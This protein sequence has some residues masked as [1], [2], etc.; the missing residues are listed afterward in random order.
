[1]V[2][3]GTLRP[4]LQPTK[5][6]SHPTFIISGAAQTPAP[7]IEMRDVNAAMSKSKKI[8]IWLIRILVVF[9]ML[10]VLTMVLSPRLIN[11]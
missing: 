3:L 7:E 2:H 10:I 9:A 5:E 8:Y 6:I 11:L 1:M 4:V